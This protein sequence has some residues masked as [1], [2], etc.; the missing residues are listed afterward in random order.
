MPGRSSV[1]APVALKDHPMRQA[2]ETP[3][4]VVAALLL[5]DPENRYTN[6]QILTVDGGWTAGY[7]REF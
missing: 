7:P 5:A 2:A 4:I 3:E 6:G 1:G